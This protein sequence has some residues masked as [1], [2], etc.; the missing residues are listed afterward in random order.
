MTT[1]ARWMDHLYIFGTIALGIYGQV[2]WKWQINLTGPIPDALNER[3]NY[4]FYIILNPWM[5]SG[6]VGAA[7]AAIFWIIALKK[8]ELTYAYPFVSLAFPGILLCGVLLFGEQVTW[9]KIVGMLLILS[10][11]MVHM[12]T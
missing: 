8:F 5:I 12:R 7:I 4:L 6:F 1:A 2:V 11:I 3:L 9:S 10:G